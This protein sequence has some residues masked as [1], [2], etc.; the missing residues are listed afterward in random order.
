MKAFLERHRTP[1]GAL[2]TLFAL[3]VA[4]VYL[5]VVP[6]GAREAD[7]A[8]RFVLLYAHSLVWVLLAIATGVWA[9]R[10]SSRV[11]RGAAYG[12]LAVYGVFLLTLA[13]Q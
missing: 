3:I 9:A 12:A 4:A 2:G 6:E 11:V 5:F 1:V 13:L 7:G 8:V 10:G